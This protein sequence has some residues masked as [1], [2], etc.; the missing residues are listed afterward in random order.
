MEGGRLLPADPDHLRLLLGAFLL[1]K[2]GR[3][4]ARDAAAGR[5]EAWIPARSLLDTLNWTS[6]IR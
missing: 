5:P 2:T 3:H 4:L 1:E 6:P